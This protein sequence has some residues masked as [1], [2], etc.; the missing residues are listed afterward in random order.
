MEDWHEQLTQWPYS[1]F[2]PLEF[3]ARIPG[4]Y[5]TGNCLPR[6]VVSSFVLGE[7]FNE[8]FVWVVNAAHEKSKR[9]KGMP[10]AKDSMSQYSQLV[11]GL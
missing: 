9:S 7:C 1:H 10:W 6:R 4:D 2:F 11:R 3:A 8:C 5:Y